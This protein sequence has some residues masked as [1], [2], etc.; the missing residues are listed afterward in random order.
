MGLFLESIFCCID[1]LVCPCTNATVSKDHILHNKFYSRVSSPTC[2]SHLLL[3]LNFRIE[4]PRWLSGLA[5]P[6]AQDVILETQIESRIGLPAWS[7]LLPLPVSL[8]LSL[9]LINK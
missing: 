4:Q 5:P 1:L 8:H 7:L 2:C 3:N 9:S 6:L